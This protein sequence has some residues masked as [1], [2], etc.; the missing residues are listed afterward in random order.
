MTILGNDPKEIPYWE[1]L[2]LLLRRFPAE[3]V[4]ADPE[5]AAR[6]RETIDRN[7]VFKTHLLKNTHLRGHVAITDF[8][9]M[10]PAPDGNRFLVYALYPKASVSVRIRFTDPRC[11]NITV[12]VGRSILNNGC[13]INVGKLL[14]RFGGGGHAGAGACTFPAADGDRYIP[15]IINILEDNKRMGK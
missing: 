11:E 2:V 13:N 6:C 7:S 8:R 3:T 10:E 15:E 9:S 5:V 1:Q 12:S 14:A 4:A